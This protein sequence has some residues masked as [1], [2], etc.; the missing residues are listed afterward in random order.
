MLYYCRRIDIQQFCFID[1]IFVLRFIGYW[2]VTS[3]H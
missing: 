1:F 2:V 3:N